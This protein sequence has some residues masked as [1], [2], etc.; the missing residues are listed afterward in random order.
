VYIK[1]KQQYSKAFLASSTYWR[2]PTMKS[3]P[4]L[5]LILMGWF[6]IGVAIFVGFV[7]LKSNEYAQNWGNP[8][9]DDTW[10]LAIVAGTLGY[11]GIYLI[12]RGKTMKNRV[13]V[14]TVIVN[15]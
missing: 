4:G 14:S 13:D 7:A 11:L 2:V 5:S 6:T 10:T 12:W 1:G 15:G 8:F 9:D 3:H